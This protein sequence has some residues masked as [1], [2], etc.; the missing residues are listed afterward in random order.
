MRSRSHPRPPALPAL[1]VVL[2]AGG[3]VACAPGDE[4]GVVARIGDEEVLWEELDAYLRDTVERP[5]ELDSAALSRLFDQ[6]LEGRLL[7][8]LAHAEGF[9]PESMEQ[10]EAAAFLLAR[11]AP[12]AVDEDEVASYYGDHRVEYAQPERIRLRQILVDTAEEAAV[13][14]A[15]LEAGEEF[16]AVARRLSKEPRA[17][18]GGDQ[19][20]LGH[21]D[22][23]LAF[24]DV[25]DRLETGDVS[26]PV[27]ADY[28]YHIFQV[29][30][31]SDAATAEYEEVA[32]D[33]RQDLERQRVDDL[34]AGFLATAR[35]R[36]G[37]EVYPQSFPFRY[38]GSHADLET[39]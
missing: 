30:A 32:D 22:L 15:A 21:D 33:I 6:Y 4:A 19:G 16:S 25:I 8:H 31:R 7:V 35:Q 36:F 14:I 17:H 10:R 28:G 2:L 26:E 1:L 13:A 23:P 11:A 39:D 37:V 20:W 3:G 12:S 18:H 9:D 24:A 34:I 38:R 29:V 5:N 27:E